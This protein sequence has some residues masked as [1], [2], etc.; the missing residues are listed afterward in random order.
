MT[1]DSFT[2]AEAAEYLGLHRSTL[3]AHQNSGRLVPDIRFKDG[4]RLYSLE[5]I[6]KYKRRWQAPNLTMEQ[7]ADLFGITKVMAFWALRKKRVIVPDGKRGRAF[8]FS[9]T[10][11]L[12]V[13]TSEK[14]LTGREEFVAG[15]KYIG[16]M[17]IVA[18]TKWAVY[19]RQFGVLNVLLLCDTKEYAEAMVS[20]E[21][22]Y[23]A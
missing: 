4:G 5:T 18:K 3:E 14:W 17:Y 15:D 19:A 13:A 2:F 16:M 12:M 20:L 1:K 21:R 6:E 22:G 9:D 8:V 7:V 10:K 11:V 23:R